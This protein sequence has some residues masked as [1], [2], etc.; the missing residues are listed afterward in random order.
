MG[1]RLNRAKGER[2]SSQVAVTGLT[3]SLKVT[4]S[5]WLPAWTKALP[6]FQLTPMEGSPAPCVLAV[7]D[8]SAGWMHPGGGLGAVQSALASTTASTHGAGERSEEHTP[9]LQSRLHLL[10][11]LFF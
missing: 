6:V 1:S 5:V 10:C 4:L 3:V 9:E 2:W 11:R 8:A 7:V